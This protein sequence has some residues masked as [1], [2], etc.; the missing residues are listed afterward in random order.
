MKTTK[1]RPPSLWRTQC[2]VVAEDEKLFRSAKIGFQKV[3]ATTKFC[4]S[5][6]DVGVVNDDDVKIL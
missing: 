1:E 5:R 4:R 6:N 3:L 2:K